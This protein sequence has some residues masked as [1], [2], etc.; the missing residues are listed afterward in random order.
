MKATMYLRHA[1]EMQELSRRYGSFSAL[2][3]HEIKENF[4][5]RWDVPRNAFFQGQ[6]R[7]SVLIAMF[8]GKTGYGKSSILN[9]IIGKTI[10]P[11]NDV[12]ACT[13]RIDTAFFR[14]DTS[15]KYYLSLSDLP[16][17]GESGQADVKYLEMYRALL[18]V[19]E[20]VI[21]TLRADQRDYSVD[22]RLF[23]GMLSSQKDRSKIVIALNCADKIEPLSRTGEITPAQ[24]RAL[25]DK[26]RQ[27]QDCFGMGSWNIVPCCAQTGYGIGTLADRIVGKLKQCIC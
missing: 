26:V 2:E 25:A 1:K 9:R 17:I 14:M 12:G 13:N 24:E 8:I 5:Y 16:G 11:I 4:A 21:Y 22:E 20:C 18:P 3:Y 7:V 27:V 19:S 6:Q 23:R 15:G 10:F